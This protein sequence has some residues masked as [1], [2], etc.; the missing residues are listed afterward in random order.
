MGRSRLCFVRNELAVPGDTRLARTLLAAAFVC[1]SE[2]RSAVLGVCGKDGVGQSRGV[3]V[4]WLQEVA[5]K[6]WCGL[7]VTVAIWLVGRRW[8]GCAQNLATTQ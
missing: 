7:L 4:L 5:V 1:V 6:W 3:V 2:L 8:C